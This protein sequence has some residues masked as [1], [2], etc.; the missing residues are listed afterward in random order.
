MEQIEGEELHQFREE[1]SGAPKV[2]VRAAQQHPY[3]YKS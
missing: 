3:H 1:F 2:R